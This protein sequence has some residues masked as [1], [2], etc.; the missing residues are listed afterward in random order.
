MGARATILAV[1]LVAACSDSKTNAGYDDFVN[2]V[3]QAYCDWAVKC[4]KASDVPKCVDDFTEEAR[5]LRS[6]AEA[7]RFYQDHQQA[8]DACVSGSPGACAGSDDFSSFCPA[9]ASI[10]LDKACVPKDGGV[11][12]K[13]TGG[14][15]DCVE[16]TF[17]V[18]NW[19]G[20]P[21]SNSLYTGTSWAL[22]NCTQMQPDLL[23]V[24]IKCPKVSFGNTDLIS[25]GCAILQVAAPGNILGD[26][27]AAPSAGKTPCAGKTVTN[28]TI[29]CY[30]KCKRELELKITSGACK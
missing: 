3:P 15:P 7:A 22:P 29:T 26:K 6:C 25:E 16:T 9:F 19:S 24:T 13:D 11:P 14:T 4:G 18:T 1:V 8:A 10:D 27:G 20:A 28:T 30:Q 12:A 21:A 5:A 2:K 17:Q 23:T